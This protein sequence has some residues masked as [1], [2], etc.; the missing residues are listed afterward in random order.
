MGA[1]RSLRRHTDTERAR[2]YEVLDDPLQGTDIGVEDGPTKKAWMV[3]WKQAG[4]SPIACFFTGIAVAVFLNVF[5][6]QS[7]AGYGFLACVVA[8]P[9]VLLIQLW[10]Y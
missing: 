1:Y 7:L 2:E 5:N 6:H 10:G 9:I 3:D 8:S 4:Y